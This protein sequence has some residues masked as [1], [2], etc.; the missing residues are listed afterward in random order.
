MTAAPRA[1]INCSRPL[2]ARAIAMAAM[3]EAAIN[4]GSGSASQAAR[5]WR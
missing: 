2:Q 5:C 4:N 1:S 3:H